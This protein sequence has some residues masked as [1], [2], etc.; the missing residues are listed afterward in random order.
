MSIELR[1]VT[2]KAST[3]RSDDSSYV[4]GYGIVYEQETELFPGFK[5]KVARGAFR[6]ASG[7][8]VKSYFNHDPA[9]ILA[10]TRSKPALELRE[11]DTGVYY[12]AP[13]PPTSYGKDLEINLERENVTGASFAFSVDDD[14]W[15]ERSD[16][17]I[18]RYIKKGTMYEIGPVTDPAY[19]QTS[20]VGR[21]K[22][23]VEERKKDMN[24]PP[25][26]DAEK[27]KEQE[28]RQNE[29]EL[30]RFKLQLEKE[31]L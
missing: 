21:A 10:T 22:A 7:Q 11:D 16:G 19:V 6:M 17:T 12:K 2:Q 3:Q 31:I 28:L 5:E 14:S 1:T 25:E 27:L 23:M 8:E 13:I 26:P 24:K 9:K 30:E 15:E 18:F 4:E 20:A 29:I